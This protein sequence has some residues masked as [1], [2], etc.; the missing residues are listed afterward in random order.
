MRN[1]NILY[2]FH[3]AEIESTNKYSGEKYPLKIKYNKTLK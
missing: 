3:S 2:R 1:K